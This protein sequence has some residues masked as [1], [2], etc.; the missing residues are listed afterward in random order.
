VT[1]IEFCGQVFG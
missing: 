1:H